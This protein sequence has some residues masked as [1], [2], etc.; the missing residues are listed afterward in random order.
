MHTHWRSVWLQVFLSFFF[1][2]FLVALGGPKQ[3]VTEASAPPP[4]ATFAHGD[5]FVTIPYDSAREGSGKLIAEIL[6]P[7][8]HI[9]GRAERRVTIAKGRGSWQQIIVPAKPIA[10]EDLVWQ[11]LR[12]RFQYEDKNV[13]P[14]TGVESI[15]RR[16]RRP[17]VRILGQSEYIAGSDAAMRILVS[18]AGNNDVA[19]TGM[20]RAELLVPDQKPRLLFSGR[21]NHRGTLLAQFRLPATHV[22]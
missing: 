18:D 12:Y 9:L 11:R 3:A 8:E 6:D 22:G 7:E 14:I 10:F 19:L 15:S 17:V 21:L 20:V 5:L 4:A 16:L 2:L 13:A 1:V